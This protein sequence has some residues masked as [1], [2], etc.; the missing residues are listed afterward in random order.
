[1]TEAIEKKPVEEVTEIAAAAQPEPLYTF[2]KLGAPD[3]FLMSQ[4][5]SKI[6]LNEFMACF[7]KDGIR[8]LI[9]TV[10]SK[11]NNEEAA[12]ED[13]S[14]NIVGL[15]VVMEIV[16]VILGN[17]PKCEAEIYKLL[18]QTS[19]LTIKEITAPGNAVMFVE[20]VIDFIKKEEFKDFIKVVSRLFK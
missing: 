16:N 19:N 7:E 18:A 12:E 20:M 15:S 5:I 11:E 2:R 4:I 13:Q 1:M 14:A 9:A 6:G 3:I 17:L 10:T 8:N